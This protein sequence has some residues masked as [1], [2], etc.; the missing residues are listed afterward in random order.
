ML[1]ALHRD[2]EA[3]HLSLFCIR[4]TDNTSCPQGYQR[5]ESTGAINR[6]E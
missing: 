5:L 4:V 3:I 2:T 1:Y 6:F